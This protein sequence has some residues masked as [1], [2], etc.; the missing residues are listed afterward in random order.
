MVTEVPADDRSSRPADADGGWDLLFLEPVGPPPRE[1]ERTSEPRDGNPDAD[2]ESALR[3]FD[4]TR[5][6]LERLV[7]EEPRGQDT[8]EPKNEKDL[9]PGAAVIPGSETPETDKRTLEDLQKMIEELEAGN[10]AVGLSAEPP[11]E[12][13][14]ARAEASLFERLDLGVSFTGS[15]WFT[16]FDGTLFV[17][18]G[19][20]PGSASTFDVKTLE[21]ELESSAQAS[22]SIHIGDHRVGFEYLPMSGEGNT[23]LREPLIFHAK[24]Y[25]AGADVESRIDFDVWAMQYDYRLIHEPEADLRLG[26]G[27][28]YWSFDSE[29]KSTDAGL[30]EHRGFSSIFPSARVSGELRRGLFSVGAQ[31]GGGLLSSQQYFFDVQGAAGI[32]WESVE[33]SAG[34]RVFH[35]DIQETTNVLDFDFQGPFVALSLKLGK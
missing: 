8:S 19:G 26:L 12:T 14:G 6:R 16:D 15:Y 32:T 9:E 3:G 4:A 31:I 2:P 25:P 22:A 13:P 23:T 30:S 24:T 29:L 33:L 34:Y 21:V 35:V 28:Y 20:K 10:D 5:L 18:R 11:V 1:P 27:G 17:T 7:A